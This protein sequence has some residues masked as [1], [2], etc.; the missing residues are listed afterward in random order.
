MGYHIQYG[1]RIVKT[2]IR[3]PKEKRI[4]LSWVMALLLTTILVYTAYSYKDVLQNYIFPG[5]AK[6]TAAALDTLVEDIRV[7]EDIG[8]AVTA[9][10][11]EIMDNAD[12]SN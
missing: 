6:I 5:D 7:G 8:D 12:L 4:K 1:K 11:L 3:M 9:F 2:Q 10:C